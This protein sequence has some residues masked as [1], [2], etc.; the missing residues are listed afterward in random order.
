VAVLA[1]LVI[2]YSSAMIGA[3][4]AGDTNLYCHL[5]KIVE[6]RRYPVKSLLGEVIPVAEVDERGLAGDRLWAVRD[7]DGKLQR[8]LTCNFCLHG[9]TCALTWPVGFVPYLGR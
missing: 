8:S 2:S 5:M 9:P 7:P 3:I 6:V 4:L 1:V